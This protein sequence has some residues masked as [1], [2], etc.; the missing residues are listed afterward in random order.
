MSSFQTNDIDQ[1]TVANSSLMPIETGSPIMRV[2]LVACVK[3]KQDHAAPAGELY[4]SPLFRKASAYCAATYDRW[5]ILSAKHGLIWPDTQIAPYDETLKDK[6]IAERR[7]WA[8]KVLEQ[9]AAW[10]A[11]TGMKP[12]YYFHAGRYYSEYLVAGLANR[13]EVPLQGLGIGKLLAWYTE[14]GF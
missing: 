4:R 3:A 1:P 8:R 7:E 2:G 11:D 13:A 6:P 14:R 9:L 5:A 12:V 10:E